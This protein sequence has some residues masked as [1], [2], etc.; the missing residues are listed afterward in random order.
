MNERVFILDDD[1]RSCKLAQMV[2]ERAGYNV[3][4]KTQAIGAT[5][6]IRAFDPDLV[7]IDVMMP[8]LSGDNLVEILNQ[9]L[10]PRPRIIYYSNKSEHEL[11]ELM[12]KT[13][14][15]GFVCKVDGPGAMVSKV[16]KYLEG[17]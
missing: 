4:S 1:E 14:A 17:A 15:D 11:R 10:D 3:M 5:N 7:L 13:G 16:R 8:A 12:E 6:S 2:L 9:K